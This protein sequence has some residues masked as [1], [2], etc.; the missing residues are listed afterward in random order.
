MDK[1]I[2]KFSEE[3]FFGFFVQ[4]IEKKNENEVFMQ[5]NKNYA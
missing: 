2:K 1:K 5:Q 4:L 3:R